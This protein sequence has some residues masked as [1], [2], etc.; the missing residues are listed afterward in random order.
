M[1]F[2]LPSLF[3]SDA[4]PVRVDVCGR[5]DVGRTRE[6]NEDAYLMADVATG[7]P[8]P[9][10]GVSGYPAREHGLLFMVADGMG[11]A[12]AGEIASGMAV[13]TVLDELATRWSR[14]SELPPAAF[15][16]AIREAAEE[17][18][19]RI[20]A[21]ACEHPEYRGMGTTAT[22]AG[23]RDDTLYLAQVGDSRAYLVRSGRA[24]QITKDQSLL[25]RLVEA[26]ELTAEEAERSARRN[27]ILQALG[28]EASV[29]IDLTH[30]QVRRGDVLILCSDGLS[31]LVKAD[32]IEELV[33]GTPDLCR[34]CD[35]LID[36]A[37]ARGGPDNITVVAVRFD[38]EGLEVARED[39]QVGHRRFFEDGDERTEADDW[40]A[41]DMSIAPT[42][43]IEV[44]T[45]QDAPPPTTGPFAVVPR[46][47]GR[48]VVRLLRMATYATP[49]A[50]AAW[51]LWRW[52][53]P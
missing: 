14:Q 6:H 44:A 30:Q 9:V 18:N 33:A 46:E 4:T 53:A 3:P 36:A 12:A 19:R 10:G 51:L 45:A 47:R 28:P 8:L 40:T 52:L 15:A 25:Q 21:C 2:T 26:G 16:R 39:D 48:T 37:N 35:A 24:L 50:I 1:T 7:A 38:G 11:G 22:I 20:H 23:L 49:A 5:T 31:G 41:I 43:E 42:D 29:I 34:L 32:E 17:A 27:I 13:Q